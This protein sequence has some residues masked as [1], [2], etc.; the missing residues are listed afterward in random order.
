M[1]ETRRYVWLYVRL[2]PGDSERKTASGASSETLRKSEL[3]VS[4]SHITPARAG[5]NVD[6]ERQEKTVL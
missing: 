4:A 6:N 1:D 3:R 2:D 5:C